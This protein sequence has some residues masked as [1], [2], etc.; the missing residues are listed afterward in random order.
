MVGELFL[1]ML[2]LVEA[3]ALLAAK[4][5]SLGI[6]SLKPFKEAMCFIYC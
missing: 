4:P 1:F 5:S 3:T 6:L 2:C